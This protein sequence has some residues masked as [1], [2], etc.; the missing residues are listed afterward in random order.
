[1]KRLFPV[2]FRLFIFWQTPNAN[3]DASPLAVK[4]FNWL[5]TRRTV[6]KGL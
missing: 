2:L 6:C 1:M 5:H 4:S 3:D